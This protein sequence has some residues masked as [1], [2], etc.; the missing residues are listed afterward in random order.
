M[1]IQ[2]CELK[3]KALEEEAKTHPERKEILRLKW[4]ALRS[5]QTIYYK[6]HPQQ[7]LINGD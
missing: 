1:N 4:R 5:A 6:F 2:D 7:K 3:M